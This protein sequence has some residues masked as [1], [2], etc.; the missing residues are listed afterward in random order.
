MTLV[1]GNCATDAYISF[2]D[3]V[4]YKPKLAV[5]CCPMCL[6]LRIDRFKSF[7]S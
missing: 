7:T 1:A 3:I 5:S 4:R 2:I 6:A